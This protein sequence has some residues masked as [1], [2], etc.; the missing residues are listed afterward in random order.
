MTDAREEWPW[1]AFR[2][3]GALV[4]QLRA[5]SWQVP[6][7]TVIRYREGL[8]RIDTIIRRRG[9]FRVLAHRFLIRAHKGRPRP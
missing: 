8:R 3:I 1:F 4:Y 9:E 5:V 6:D 7:F 2:D